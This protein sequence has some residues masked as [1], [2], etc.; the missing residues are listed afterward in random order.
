MKTDKRVNNICGE[1]CSVALLLTLS[2]IIQYPVGVHFLYFSSFYSLL[3][4][5]ISDDQSFMF[6]LW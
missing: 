6:F 5:P 1:D 2:G 4:I 3:Y